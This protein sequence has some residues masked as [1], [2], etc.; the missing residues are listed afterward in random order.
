MPE[1]LR[2]V[3]PEQDQEETMP[4]SEHKAKMKVMRNELERVMQIMKA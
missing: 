2:K 3:Y 4:V 1:E